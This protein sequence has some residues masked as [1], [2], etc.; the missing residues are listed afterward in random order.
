MN[1]K[2]ANSKNAFVTIVG[3]AN[4]GKSSLLNA[5]VGE[6]IAA[7]SDKPQTTRTK[8]TGVLTKGETQFVFM[9][10]P[11]MHK[12]KNKLSEQTDTLQALAEKYPCCSQEH[13]V[14]TTH[15]NFLKIGTFPNH[16][17]YQSFLKSHKA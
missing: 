10:T 11:G 9:D 17:G 4:A 2:N 1:K 6:K 7:V 16:Q 5:L 3:R 15:H 13:L 8:I 12:A 14:H